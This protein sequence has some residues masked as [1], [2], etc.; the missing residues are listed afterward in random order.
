MSRVK[1]EVQRAMTV[2]EVATEI[3]VSFQYVSI[4]EKKA[5]AKVKE[6]LLNRFGGS[7]TMYDIFPNLEKETI[8][9]KMLCL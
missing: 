7:V 3:G 8:H 1:Y 6:Y 2:Q 9:D 5:L 4:I